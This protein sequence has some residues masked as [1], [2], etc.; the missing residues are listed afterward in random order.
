[1]DSQEWEALKDKFE[2][3]ERAGR[4]IEYLGGTL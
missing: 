1:M 4:P 3:E 2:A